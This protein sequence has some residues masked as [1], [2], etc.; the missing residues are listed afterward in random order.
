M[1]Q[2]ILK[3]TRCCENNYLELTDDQYR[4]LNWLDN[5]EFM[6]DVVVEIVDSYEF[7]KI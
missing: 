1:V 3:D 4:L 7:Q 5:K 2:V 6:E